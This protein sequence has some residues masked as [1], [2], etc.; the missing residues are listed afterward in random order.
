M[1]YLP[2]VVAVMRVGWEGLKKPGPPELKCT[3]LKERITGE[4]K[5]GVNHEPRTVRRASP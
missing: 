4:P 5:A 3:V 1:M 2:V